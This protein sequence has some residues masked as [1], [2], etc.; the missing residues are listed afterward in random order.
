MGSAL[1]TRGGLTESQKKHAEV[2][3]ISNYDMMQ[4]ILNKQKI[5]TKLVKQTLTN[6]T[7]TSP[8]VKK[9][10]VGKSRSQRKRS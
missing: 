4:M 7:F 10:S 8:V 6:K 3:G 1:S 5:E 9:K 2:M